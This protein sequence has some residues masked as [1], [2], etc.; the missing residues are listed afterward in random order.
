MENNAKNNKIYSAF[1][2]AGSSILLVMAVF[3][4]SGYYYVSETIIASNAEP[5]L[6][7][8]VPVLFAH[9]SFHLLGLSAFGL[10]ALELTIDA[11]K[12]LAVLSILIFIDALLALYL[13]GLLPGILLTIAA[14]CFVSASVNQNKR[15]PKK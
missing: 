15:L 8:I 13:G 11:K 3:H 2:I 4:G 7:D 14:L 6:K 9:P 1:C 5:F 10:L 12:V